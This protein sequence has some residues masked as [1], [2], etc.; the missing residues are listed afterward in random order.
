MAVHQSFSF[1]ATHRFLDSLSIAKFTLVVPKIKLYSITEQV[2]FR[3][4]MNRP[5]DS[6]F[7][8]VEIALNGIGINMASDVFLFTMIHPAV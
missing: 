7:Q 3:E 1:K 2:L 5:V 6:S 4:I 8:Q